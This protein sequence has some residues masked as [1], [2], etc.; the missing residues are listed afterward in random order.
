M[1]KILVALLLFVGLSCSCAAK[2]VVVGMG[3]FDPF[4][5]E[6]EDSGIFTDIIRAVF[7][8]MPNHEAIF[9]YGMVNKRLWVFFEEG[10][11][12]AISNLYDSV[13]LQACR[14]DPTFRFR[15]MAIS[16]KKSNFIINKMT[17]LKGKS[18]M[19]FQGAKDFFGLEFAKVI[20]S[21]HYTE[22]VKP[23]LQ[24][25][26]L[27]HDRVDVSV[28]DLFLF[29]RTLEKENIDPGSFNFHDIFPR[30]YSHMGFHDEDVCKLFNEG[31]KK[32]KASGEYE[33]IYRSYLERLGY[34]SE[35][36]IRE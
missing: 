6:S 7:R 2:E 22:L 20:D 9:E 28:G 8:H 16:L 30:L 32:I 17:D 12:D 19:S 23:Q 36:T 5:V 3:S 33:G 1:N 25:I 15:D 26:M 21:R 18:I 34:I 4:V 11:I 14:S 27:F 29:L 24:A 10:R 31:L 13:D 35:N